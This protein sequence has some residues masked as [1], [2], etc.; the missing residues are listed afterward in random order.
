MAMQIV[1]KQ[2]DKQSDH[3]LNKGYELSHNNPPHHMSKVLEE[4]TL[5]LLGGLLGTLHLIGE[6]FSHRQQK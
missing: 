1:R 2:I 4:A 3:R 5:Q 6:E